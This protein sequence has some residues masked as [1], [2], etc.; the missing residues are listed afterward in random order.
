MQFTLFW[1][2]FFLKDKLLG[3]GLCSIKNYEGI[4]RNL[5]SIYWND[6]DLLIDFFW[7]RVLSY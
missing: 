3:F 5:L 2:D 1:I 7:F 6:G 4:H